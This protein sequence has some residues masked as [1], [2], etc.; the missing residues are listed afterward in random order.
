MVSSRV[1]SRNGQATREYVA[2]RTTT[3]PLVFLWMSTILL[4]CPPRTPGPHVAI[5]LSRW[6]I[7]FRVPNDIALYAFRYVT[8]VIPSFYYDFNHSHST[9]KLGH[10]STK[11]ARTLTV[12]LDNVVS[13]AITLRADPGLAY[14]IYMVPH[15]LLRA[16]LARPESAYQY[17]PPRAMT[18]HSLYTAHT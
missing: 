2:S 3:T 6:K 11:H 18:S 17:R 7:L 5:P 12:G 4:G 9:S 10:Q 8:S 15:L 13:Y 16:T 1:V 14:E